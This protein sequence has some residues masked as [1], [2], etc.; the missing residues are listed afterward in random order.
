MIHHQGEMSLFDSQHLKKEFFVTSL[1]I[2]DG[3]IRERQKH[4]SSRIRLK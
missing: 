2:T 3:I 4:N 1:K